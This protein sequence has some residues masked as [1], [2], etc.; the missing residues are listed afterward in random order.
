MC[1][2]RGVWAGATGE[3]LYLLVGT[4]MEA[5]VARKAL[6]GMAF[7][8]WAELRTLVTHPPPGHQEL[9]GEQV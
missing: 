9:S 8:A 4:I 6:H 1:L 2:R 5:D 3:A 7:C